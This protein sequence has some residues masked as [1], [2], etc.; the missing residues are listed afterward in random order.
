MDVKTYLK[1][2]I[3][4]LIFLL[5]GVLIGIACMTGLSSVDA[6]AQVKET[7]PTRDGATTKVERAP[8]SPQTT[9]CD[10]SSFECVSAGISSGSAAFG[11]LLANRMASD[12]LSVNGYDL[13]KLHDSTLKML[14]H[15]GL[16]TTGESQQIINDAK[17]AKPLRLR[18]S[19]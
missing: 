1:I 10:E 15:K 3:I 13:L 14:A 18:I 7:L 16:L 9:A 19:Q 8:A 11:I 2:S 12:T 17:V 4:N 5:V 6:Q